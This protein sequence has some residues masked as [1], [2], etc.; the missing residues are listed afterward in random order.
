LFPITRRL[1]ISART[2]P[3]YFARS[4]PGLLRLLG[5]FTDAAAAIDGSK[6]KAVNNRS[7]LRLQRQWKQKG[8][9]DITARTARHK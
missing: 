3:R 4:A 6:F 5:L 2:T 8:A 7:Q 9:F 1:P